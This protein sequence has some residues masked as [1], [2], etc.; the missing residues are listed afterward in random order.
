MYYFKE[1]VRIKVM[2]DNTDIAMIIRFLRML[3]R[4]YAGYTWIRGNM[5]ERNYILIQVRVRVQN[6]ISLYDNMGE[7]SA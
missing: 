3:V 5:D 6:R 1:H 4:C 2:A 7:T